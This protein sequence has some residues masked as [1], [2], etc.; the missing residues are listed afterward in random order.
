MSLR[1]ILGLGMGSLNRGFPDITGEFQQNQTTVHKFKGSLPPAPEVEEMQRRWQIICRA[2]K[3][4]KSI[5]RI[6]V[7]QTGTTNI[8][9]DNPKLVYQCLN[10]AMRLW[11]SSEVFYTEIEQNFRNEVNKVAGK[12]EPFEVFLEINDS[13]NWNLPWDAWQFR[14]DYKNC[15]LIKSPSQY[16][17]ADKQ[18][19]LEGKSLPSRGR[20]LCISGNGEGL[21]LQKDEESIKRS[22]GNDRCELKFIKQPTPKELRDNLLNDEKNWQILYYGGHSD[23][24]SVKG[25]LHINQTENDNSVTIDYLKDGLERSIFQGLE[26]LILNSCLSM[27]LAEDLVAGGLP[28]PSM[29]VMRA[30]IPDKIAHDCVKSL[31]K[32]LGEGDPLF[33][34]VRKAKDDLHR[35]EDEFPGASAIPVL[36]QQPTFDGLTLPDLEWDIPVTPAVNI[37]EYRTNNYISIFLSNLMQHLGIALATT[38]S[39]YML[40]GPIVAPFVNRLGMENHRQ[41]RPLIAKTLYNLASLINVNY[42]QPYY[43]LAVLSDELN[44]DRG[45]LEAMQNAVWRGLPDASAQISK[46]FIRKD[47]HQPALKAIAICLENAKHDGVTS[48]CIKNRGW[49]RF[50]EKQYDDAQIDFQTAIRLED[51]SPEAHCFL[52]QVL[53]TKGKPLSALE[54]WEKTIKYSKSSIPE[55]DQCIQMAKQNLQTQGNIK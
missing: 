21:D 46:L 26:L 40:M 16:R 20:I 35:W 53:E 37:A 39:S 4:S 3:S 36:C 31:F 23:S 54:H 25:W 50:K 19:T 15:E 45:A 55:Q 8:S 51:D 11:L 42:A 13:D 7:N 34:A 12:L 29:I 5:S 18:A 28:L 9:E 44:D 22:L 1:F 41:N 14:E 24:N 33:L 43:N 32:Y 17:K 47:K 6:K 10:E 49:V 30:P 48:A 52:A 2:T 27:K 38:A